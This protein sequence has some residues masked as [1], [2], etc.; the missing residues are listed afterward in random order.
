MIVFRSVLVTSSCVSYNIQDWV[1]DHSR[2]SFG[3][4]GGYT[5]FSVEY[6]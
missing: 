2:T 3:F 1:G 5:D 6:R 4:E